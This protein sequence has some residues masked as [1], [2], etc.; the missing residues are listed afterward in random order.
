MNE[1]ENENQLPERKEIRF[2]FGY[3]KRSKDDLF[4]I[5]I[6]E[7]RKSIRGFKRLLPIAILAILIWLITKNII[8][9]IIMIPF[10]A[11]LLIAIIGYSDIWRVRK[12]WEKEQIPRRAY[13]EER[14]LNYG[15]FGIE[16]QEKG[17]L[18]S[19]KETFVWNRFE[20]MAEWGKYLFLIPPKKKKADMFELREDEIGKE[21]F[22]EFRDFAKSKLK[23]RLITNYK[24]II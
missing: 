17:K 14:I 13:V 20:F 18:G 1:S 24:E 10:A 11:L 21:N 15:D 12:K 23:Y 4:K 16:F 7:N 22:I 2:P 5:F 9:L 19:W 6:I 3:Q 8:A